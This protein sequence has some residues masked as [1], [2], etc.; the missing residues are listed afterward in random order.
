M[1]CA[2]K[3]SGSRSIIPVELGI[4]DF[5]HLAG[6]SVVPKTSFRSCDVVCLIAIGCD[7]LPTDQRIRREPPSTKMT[8]ADTDHS[9]RIRLQNG[10]RF[11]WDTVVTMK[12]NAE[13]RHCLDHSRSPKTKLVR[14]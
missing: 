3:A 4:G 10:W 2:T 1:R 14:D 12:Q 11:R 6:L 9:H 7:T 8:L 5:Q 13:D